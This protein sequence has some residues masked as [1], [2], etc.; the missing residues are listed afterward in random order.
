MAHDLICRLTVDFWPVDAD[1]CAGVPVERY[2]FFG[3]DEDDADK[4][5]LDKA[6]DDSRFRKVV[7]ATEL[8]KHHKGLICT[9][10]HKMVRLDKI[11]KASC[12][13]GDDEGSE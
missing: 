8:G 12:P 5:M 3:V 9:M 2:Q 13:T 11:A 6:T 7:L 4:R 10:A 1:K